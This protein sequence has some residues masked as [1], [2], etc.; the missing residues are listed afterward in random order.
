MLIGVF[1]TYLVV[2]VIP[3]FSSI[4]MVKGISMSDFYSVELK[5]VS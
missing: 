1:N 4:V 2:G 5:D 3:D